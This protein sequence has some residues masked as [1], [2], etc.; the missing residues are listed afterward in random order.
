MKSYSHRLFLVL[1]SF[2]AFA[3]QTSTKKP[4]FVQKC[5]G[6]TLKIGIGTIT[7]IAAI[8]FSLKWLNNKAFLEALT[9]FKK[10]TYYDMESEI[11]LAQVVDVT[12]AKEQAKILMNIGK[13]WFANSENKQILQTLVKTTKL[14]KYFNNF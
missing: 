4:S 12:A 13:S 8:Y 11:G 3:D 6:H 1:L 14:S 7:G 10:E 5:K 9:D 2:A